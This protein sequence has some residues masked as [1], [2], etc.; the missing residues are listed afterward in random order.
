MLAAAGIGAWKRADARAAANLLGRA[1]SLLPAGEAKRAEIL[2]E[3]GMTLSQLGDSAA[4]DAAFTQAIDEADAWATTCLRPGRESSARAHD[5]TGAATPRARHSRAS[6]DPAL[7][8]GGKRARPRPRLARAR[9]RPRLSAGTLHGLARRL[10]ARSTVL[11]EI[12]VVHRR[13]PVRDRLRGVPR[14]T[15]VPEALEVCE[16]L[17]EEATDRPGTCRP[18]IPRGS[19]RLRRA[20]R[21]GR[22][23]PR[24]SGQRVPRP[25]GR[26]QPGEHER[27]D[28]RC[29]HAVAEDHEAAEAAFRACCETFERFDDSAA[30]ASVAAELGGSLLT[31]WRLEESAGVECSG[32]GS[33]SRRRRHRA[34][35]LADP[36]GKAPRAR[37]SPDAEPLAMEALSLAMQTDARIRE[38]CCSTLPLS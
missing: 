37:Q 29:V 5:C 19:P 33:R 24:R 27:P 11:P 3:L 34:A 8:G 36:Q 14:S 4:A 25:P 2:C 20:R 16:R 15:P 23:P 28:S 22:S 26:L 18:R 7:R 35:L 32:R 9:V 12:R 21:R 6:R 38:T 31:Q 13:L 30:L 10:R 17:L 1:A